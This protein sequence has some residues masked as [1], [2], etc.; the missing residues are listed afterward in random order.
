MSRTIRHLEE[1]WEV[2]ATG[3]GVA[4][5][6]DVV[7]DASNWG[8]VFRRVSNP[9]KGSFRGSLHSVGAPDVARVPEADLARSLDVAVSEAKAELVR[10]LEDPKWDW[11]TAEG[12]AKD[13]GLSPDQVLYILESDPGTFIRSRVPDSNGRPLYSTRDRYAQ[14]RGFLDRLRST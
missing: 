10:A 5:G 6:F 7:P 4:S 11:R 8:L 12:A 9:R 1:E 2:E 13:T 14:R 3:T